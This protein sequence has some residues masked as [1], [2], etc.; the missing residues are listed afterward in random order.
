MCKANAP[1]PDSINALFRFPPLLDDKLGATTFAPRRDMS[2]VVRIAKPAVL[3]VDGGCSNNKSHNHGSRQMVAVVTDAEGYVLVEH[4]PPSGGSNNIA[5]LLAVTLALEWCVE[6]GIRA[7]EVK[8]D[9]QN[10]LSWA[11]CGKLGQKLNDRQA[12]LALQARIATARSDV[13]HKLTWVPRERNLAGHYIERT[14]SL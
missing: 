5:E 10:N 2:E 3:Y 13:T 1:L 8:T 7:V 4:R 9:S 11:K 14:Y 12:V 6:N